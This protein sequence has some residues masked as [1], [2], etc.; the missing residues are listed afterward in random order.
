MHDQLAVHEVEAVRVGVAWPLDHGLNWLEGA[1]EWAT[2]V[3]GR[4]PTRTLSLGQSRELVHVLTRVS[5]P[6]DAEA[7]V[8]VERLEQPAR[9][10]RVMQGG[11]R[12]PSDAPIAE[13]V[14]LDHAEA[15]DRVLLAHPERHPASCPTL[16]TAQLPRPDGT[17]VAPTFFSRRKSG[18]KLYST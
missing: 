7:K 14:A 9:S 10:V 6:R 18:G 4:R 17:Y 5:A 12:R 16:S 2:R 8:K 15:S 11:M 3:P 1:R 13:K